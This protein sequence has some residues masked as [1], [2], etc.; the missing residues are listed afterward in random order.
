LSG[1]DDLFLHDGSRIAVIGAGPAG[2][3]FARY[4]LECAERR[5]ISVQVLL[6]DGRSFSRGGP[7]GCNMCAGV[8]AA[9]LVE[10]LRDMGLELPPEAME[11]RIDRY[12][13]VTPV[14]S[15]TLD[16][17]QDSG[18]IYTVFRGGGPAGTAAAAQGFD[19]RLLSHALSWGAGFVPEAVSDVILPRAP[20][21]SVRLQLASG[22]IHEADLVV[23]AFGVHSPLAKTLTSRLPDYR[24][25]PFTHAF[26]AELELGESV[27]DRLFGG[28]VHVFALGVRGISFAALTPKRAHVT[29]TLVG[30]AAGPGAMESFL[31]N[32]LVRRCLPPGWQL[33]AQ[34]CRC[35]PRLP[36]GPAQR[37]FGDRI[38]MVGDA[39]RSRLYKNGLESAYVTGRAAA[40]TAVAYGISAAAFEAHYAPTCQSVARDSAAGRRLFWI[41][42]T[43]FVRRSLSAI[44][45]RA[46]RE[47]QRL[48]PPEK[49]VIGRALW[50]VF[51]GD[52]AYTAILR[53]A[54]RP[55]VQLHFWRRGL[56]AILGRMPSEDAMPEAEDSHAGT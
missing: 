5:G 32:P 16:Q 50:G 22:A 1:R 26:Q 38:V 9:T 7:A 47:E 19:S 39:S 45:V 6:Y 11:R 44:L 25:P 37:P 14:G 54:L 3:F 31:S 23:G 15:V 46:V 55:G 43:L 2:S 56:P 40:E 20:W 30:D 28:S 36:F 21:E 33:P 17:P 27:V 4:A 29:A 42:D 35:R 12:R 48:D 51:T 49:R 52:Q 8:L 24:L 18:P 53:N 41:K 13:L 34:H 10:K